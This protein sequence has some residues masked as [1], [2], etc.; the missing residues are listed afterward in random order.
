M[1]EGLKYIKEKVDGIDNKFT[2]LDSRFT[3]LISALR[4]TYAERDHVDELQR[5]VASLRKIVQENRE[6]NIRVTAITGAI[7]S[8]V[9]VLVSILF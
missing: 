9:T 5:E 2:H 6:F 4:D 8:I 1:E 7:I 3:E